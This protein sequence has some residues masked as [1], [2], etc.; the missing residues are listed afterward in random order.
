MPN[1][2]GAKFEDQVEA[3]FEARPAVFS[4]VYG[5]PS[6][7]ILER[8]KELEIKTIGAATTIDE[9]VACEKPGIDAVVATGFEAGGHRVSFLQSAENSLTGTFVQIP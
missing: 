9:A 5:I 7:S 8:C 3:I 4:F 1:D 6:N 2:L